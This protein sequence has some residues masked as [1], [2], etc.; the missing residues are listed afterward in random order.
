MTTITPVVARSLPKVALHDHLDG[1][2]RPAT[3]V[4]LAGP[5]G[6]ELPTTD[7]GELAAHLTR[8]ASRR[9][10]VL[11]LSGFE[12]TVGV[13]QT[14]DAV[15]RVARE[16]IED[17][18]ADGVV[19]AELRFAPELNLAG[20]LTR[21]DVL[22]AALSG[23]AAGPIP[24]GLIVDG[25]RTSSPEVVSASARAAARWADRG[26]VGFDLAGAEAWHPAGVHAEAIGIARDAGLGLTLHAGEAAGPQMISEA[27]ER[28][29]ASRIGHGVTLADDIGPD[30]QFGPVARRLHDLGVVLEV[31]PTSNVHTGAVESLASHP[32]QR[33]RDL[34]FAVTINTDNRLMSDVTMSSEIAVVAAAFD[35]DADDV[36]DVA[37]TAMRAAFCDDATRAAVEAEITDR[38][39]AAT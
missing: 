33:F 3:L 8:G 11:Y 6:V 39:R 12:S 28:F 35:W 20:G 18:A 19:Y 4:D 22:E 1:G 13:L 34:G 30:G 29:G 25:M 14:A 7:P 36:V 31:C 23:M 38:A 15:E 10:L 5:A 24:S 17:L 37:H 26:V 21:D 9:D 16:A 2:L 27:V 32:L